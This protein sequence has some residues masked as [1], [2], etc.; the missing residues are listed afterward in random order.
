MILDFV[1]DYIVPFALKHGGAIEGATVNLVSNGGTI[2]DPPVGRWRSGIVF[3]VDANLDP[4]EEVQ[5]LVF[6]HQTV[7][8]L[9]SLCV[10]GLLSVKVERRFSVK[11]K[12]ISSAGPYRPMFGLAGEIR[13]V[14]PN[15]QM[16]PPYPEWTHFHD[17]TKSLV[18][19]SNTADGGL[20]Y[21]QT[22]CLN[23]QGER[24]SRTEANRIMQDYYRSVGE[25]GSFF[26]I[27]YDGNHRMMH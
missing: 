11:A 1:S 14:M 15:G 3:M 12:S 21:L 8:E 26:D 27:A 5:L 25:G 23:E 22:I 9:R 20:L 13:M 4:G 18:V 19:R 10:G 24:L 2:T 16:K 7:K 17:Q 6:T